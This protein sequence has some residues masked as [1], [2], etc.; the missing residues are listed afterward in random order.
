MGAVMW[1]IW[2]IRIHDIEELV[3]GVAEW[4]LQAGQKARV[5][6]GTVSKFKGGRKREMPLREGTRGVD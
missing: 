2:A 4:V 6:E 5:A 1:V 3:R